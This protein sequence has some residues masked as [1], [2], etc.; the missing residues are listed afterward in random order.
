MPPMFPKDKSKNERQINE[1]VLKY[2]G[3]LLHNYKHK[4]RGVRSIYIIKVR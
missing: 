4:V 3:E 1:L 2:G